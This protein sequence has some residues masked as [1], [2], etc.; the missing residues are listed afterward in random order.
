MIRLIRWIKTQI[1]EV[2][3]HPALLMWIMGNELDLS[4]DPQ[5]LQLLNEMFDF[6]R[7]YTYTIHRRRVSFVN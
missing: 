3:N 7:N 6:I 1:E 5:M 4:N 2:G